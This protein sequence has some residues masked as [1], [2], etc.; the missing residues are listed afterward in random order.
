M[1]NYIVVMTQEYNE[2]AFKYLL[3]KSLRLK[4]IKYLITDLEI[5]EDYIRGKINGDWAR[6]QLDTVQH[7]FEV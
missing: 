5:Y 2:L 4:P 1:K 6:F 3:S 7:Y